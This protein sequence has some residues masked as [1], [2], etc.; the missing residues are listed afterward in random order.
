MQLRK[1]DVSDTTTFF[2]HEKAQVWYCKKEKQIEYFNG[3]GFHPENG[4]VL[5]P[6]TNYMIE[7]YVFNQIPKK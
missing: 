3:P 2:K 6:I 1:I 4:K 5:K 7:K